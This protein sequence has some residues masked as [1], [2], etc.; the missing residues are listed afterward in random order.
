MLLITEVNDNVN[1]ITEE[2]D[3]EKQYH[4]DG[5]FMQAEQKIETAECTHQ[6]H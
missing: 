1:L 5:V 6:E 2:V 3:G 4:I